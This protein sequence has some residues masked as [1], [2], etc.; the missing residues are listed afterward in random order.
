MNTLE[1]IVVTLNNNLMA[2]I[3]KTVKIV[4]TKKE[5]ESLDNIVMKFV[6]ETDYNDEGAT[7]TV[8]YPKE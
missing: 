8:T 5:V 7:Y 4:L 1:K 3:T 2:D 6:V